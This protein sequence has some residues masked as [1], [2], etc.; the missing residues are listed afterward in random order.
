LSGPAPDV[1]VYHLRL[2]VAGSTPRAQRA[3]G[4]LRRLCAQHLSAVTLEIVDIYQQPWLAALDQVI[5]APTLVKL[6][7][8]PVRRIIGDLSDEPRVL[9][10]LNLPLVSDAP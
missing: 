4:N 7:P 1:P 3:I 8:L 6:M 5:A 2:F 10:A 9:H